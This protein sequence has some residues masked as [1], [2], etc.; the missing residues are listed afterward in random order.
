MPDQQS[1]EYNALI[2][3]AWSDP[4]FKASL[5]ADPVGTLQQEGWKVDDNTSIDVIE[6]AENHMVLVI[7]AM[8]RDLSDEQLDSAAGGGMSIYTPSV[9]ACA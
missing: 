3:K 4:D 6:T 9:G 5:L 2:A 1:H 7:P 8:P